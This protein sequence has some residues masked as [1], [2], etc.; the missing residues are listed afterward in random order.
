MKL[1]STL[2]E[3]FKN[4]SRTLD[5]LEE[6]LNCQCCLCGFLTKNK[7]AKEDH[8]TFCLARHL[9]LSLYYA[10]PLNAD[11]FSSKYIEDRKRENVNEHLTGQLNSLSEELSSGNFS[12][13]AKTIAS[14]GQAVTIQRATFSH[15]LEEETDMDIKMTSSVHSNTQ[16]T[17]AVEPHSQSTK[18]KQSKVTRYFLKSQL[19]GVEKKSKKKAKDE[20]KE[21][22]KDE[23]G[24]KAKEKKGK[25]EEKEEDEEEDEEEE[26]EEEKEEEEEEEEKEE[27]KKKKK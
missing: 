16:N 15:I 27:E 7:R 24:N 5:K 26:E 10:E 21:G 25:K 18:K 22:T 9:T 2:T 11:L 23:G 19:A 3:K 12:N 17:V 13:S 8:E 14:I 4:D 6:Y 20:R 1:L